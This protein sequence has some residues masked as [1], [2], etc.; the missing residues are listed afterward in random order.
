MPIPP[1]EF[2]VGREDDAYVHVED[3]SVSRRHALILNLDEG[4]FVEDTGSVNGTAAHG[5]YITSRMKIDFGDIVHIGS[6][7]FRVD[8]E[9]AGEA[10]A[11]PSVNMRPVNRAYMSRDTERL[12]D[13]GEAPRRVETLSPDRLSAP[14][15]SQGADMD[16]DELNAVIMREPEVPAVT[17]LPIIRPGV[18]STPDRNPATPAIPVP[19]PHHLAPSRPHAEQKIPRPAQVPHRPAPVP[20]APQKESSVPL[21]ADPEQAA[22]VMKWVWPLLIFLAGMGIG[23]LLGLV[24][25]RIFIEL[26]GKAASLP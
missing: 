9:V 21:R 17:R 14:A 18:R 15:V 6:V 22:S 13:L 5:A 19:T 11:T 3:P 1:G 2:A 8:P 23:L 16:A 10:E 12:P 26:G 7:P 25:A 4:F 20:V 24:F